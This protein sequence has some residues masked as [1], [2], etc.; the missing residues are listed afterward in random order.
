MDEKWGADGKHLVSLFGRVAQPGARISDF[1]GLWTPL[2]CTYR[3][4]SL[5]SLPAP[6]A[7][8]APWLRLM[9]CPRNAA[10]PAARD[11]G[12]HG[13]N[14][15]SL[16]HLTKKCPGEWQCCSSHMSSSLLVC[17]WDGE[18]G[19]QD[20]GC[21]MWDAGWGMQDARHGRWEGWGW[22]TKMWKGL[23]PDQ[24]GLKMMQECE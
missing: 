7:N 5:P 10:P 23:C 17:I 13:S 14:S 15:G 24:A 6:L 19:I 12:E 21:G 8:A 2:Q 11:I 20:V 1:A 22:S 18:C 16:G 4:V 3:T 9:P